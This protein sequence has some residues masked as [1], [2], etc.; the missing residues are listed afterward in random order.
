ML[1][2]AGVETPQLEEFDGF[3]Q[4]LPDEDVLDYSVRR[5]GQVLTVAGPHPYPPIVSSLTPGSAAMDID[6]KVGDVIQSVDGEP[7]ATFAELRDIV[8]E[9]DGA[10]MLLKV[11]R[12]GQVIDFTL[13]P[14][15]M[16]LPTQEGGFETRWLIGISGGM[17]FAPQTASPGVLASIA[18]GADQTWYII[19][20]SI[21]GL[22][23]V[24]SGAISSCNIRGPIGIAQTSGEIAS[25]GLTSFIWFIAVLSTAVGLLNLFPVPVLDGG[26]LVFHAYEA[27]TGKPPSDNALRVLMAIGLALLLT[28]MGFALMNDLTCP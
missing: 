3:V 5:D 24:I 27:V 25:Q 17:V 26:H 2:I 12:D 8:G 18:Y 1:A 13:A 11:W 7:V 20:S 23:H 19:T 6:M 4:K 15:R 14:R 28:L 16:D 10:P 21:S 22:T 9:S